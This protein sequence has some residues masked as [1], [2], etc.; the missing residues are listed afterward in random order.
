MR[1]SVVVVVPPC[2]DNLRG[3]AEPPVEVFVHA[4]VAKPADEALRKR[5]TR[6][7]DSGE[8]V[9]SPKYS[10]VKSSTISDGRKRRPS[11]S[12]VVYEVDRPALVRALR[13]RHRCPRAER[14]LAPAKAANRQPLL[15]IDPEQALVLDH[16]A[17]ALQQDVQPPMAKRR[18]T[19]L[20]NEG[21]LGSGPVGRHAN[22]QV[23][24]FRGAGA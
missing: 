24:A 9:T 8:S 14:M 5:V 23:G 1:S 21:M 17:L 15:A 4:L 18:E 13:D 22:K 11:S 6:T 2:L 20:P 19:L 12:L 10:R 7:P 16:H 3:V